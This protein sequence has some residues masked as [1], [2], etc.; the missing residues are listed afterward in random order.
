M[1]VAVWTLPSLLMRI[2]PTRNFPSLLDQLPMVSPSPQTYCDICQIQA[3]GNTR[4]YHC[5]I[6]ENGKFDICGFVEAAEPL[7]W[8]MIMA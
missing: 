5:D 2:F 8:G 6:C 3:L 4:I 1:L 7:V